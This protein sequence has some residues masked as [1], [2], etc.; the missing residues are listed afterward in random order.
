MSLMNFL[1]MGS[2]HERDILNHFD[3]RVRFEGEKP[4]F[5]TPLVVI[6]FTNRC[7]S[8]L[9]ADYLLH[10]GR[11]AGLT[12]ALN[13]PHVA[14]ISQRIG[15]DSFP[16]Y[17]RREA[18]S[19]CH[20]AARQ[21]GNE[22]PV[23]GVK[24]SSS[25]LAMLLRWNITKMFNGL[26]IYHAVRQD[27]IGQAISMVI[28]NSTG[29]WIS[30]ME[31][32]TADA[33]EYS[34]DEIHRWVNRFTLENASGHLLAASLN[35]PRR[36]FVYEGFSKD[37]LPGVRAAVEMLGQDASDISVSEPSIQRQSN[38]LNEEFRHRYLADV[39]AKMMAGGPHNG[40]L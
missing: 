9:L 20:S 21:T 15:V 29:K 6:L 13:G 33:P 24:A 3:G 40:V 31:A 37:P 26:V 14:E 16:E 38:A 12:E 32:E 17:V 1:T 30:S 19:A 5:D 39:R 27:I 4:V 18:N 35:T 34:Y 8:N 2:S 22:S 7:G 10:T 36:T 11:Y 28:A 23:F 25:Q